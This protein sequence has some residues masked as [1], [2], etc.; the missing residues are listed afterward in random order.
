MYLRKLLGAKQYEITMVPEGWVAHGRVV[1]PCSRV[2]G[3]IP[4]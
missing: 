2:A 1:V 3:S 4:G